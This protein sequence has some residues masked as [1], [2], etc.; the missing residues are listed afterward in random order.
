[1]MIMSWV[2]RQEL[3][4]CGQAYIRAWYRGWL[5]RKISFNLV[6][7]TFIPEQLESLFT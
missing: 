3:G 1:M 5:A 6:L 7:I 2:D 4:P